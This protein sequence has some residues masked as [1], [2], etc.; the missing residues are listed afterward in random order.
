MKKTFDV[1]HFT[2][3]LRRKCALTEIKKFKKNE[4]ITTYLLKRNQMHILLKGEAY[5][6]RYDKEGNRRIIYYLT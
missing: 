2:E 1:E 3:E 5:L 6:A 4:I